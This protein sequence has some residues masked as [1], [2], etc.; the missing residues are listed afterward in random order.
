MKP[1]VPILLS[2]N[3][4]FVDTAG[5]LA[6]QDR[7]S[8][9]G[10]HRGSRS[11]RQLGGLNVVAREPAK[12]SL[13]ATPTAGFRMMATSP[14]RL[15]AHFSASL[16]KGFPPA[17]LPFPILKVARCDDAYC[18]ATP[19][20]VPSFLRHGRVID[21]QIRIGTADQAIRL[22]QQSC[23]V[24]ETG[25]QALYAR[26]SLDESRYDMYVSACLDP[27][28]STNAPQITRIG[29]SDCSTWPF[30]PKTAVGQKLQLDI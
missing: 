21:D 23:L 17:F 7:G 19:T 16:H 20:R 27:P 14:D 3:G 28:F 26:S 8:E 1:S 10:V 4:G 6:L 25:A 15:Q 5:D 29:L 30:S 12:K 18:G 24:L 22:N 11:I 13:P 2:L 9:S